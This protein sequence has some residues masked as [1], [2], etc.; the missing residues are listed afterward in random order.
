M[1]RA[2]V[3][4]ISLGIG[5]VDVMIFLK[6]HHPPH[7]HFICESKNAELKMDFTGRVHFIK[8]FR[9]G[10]VVRAFEFICENQDWLM[11]SWNERQG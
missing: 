8:N 10:D 3:A 4:I 1:P 2:K 5:K 6:D 7:V 11:E 9:D